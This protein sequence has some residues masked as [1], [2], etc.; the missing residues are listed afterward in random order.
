MGQQCI[1]RRRRCTDEC[2][3]RHHRHFGNALHGLPRLTHSVVSLR[4]MVYISGLEHS[5]A[6]QVQHACV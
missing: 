5:A 3:S 4:V 6:R 2:A 1:R